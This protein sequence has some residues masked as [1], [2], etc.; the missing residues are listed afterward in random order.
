M[1]KKI[2]LPIFALIF[3]IFFSGNAFAENNGSVLS[4]VEIRFDYKKA[5]SLATNQ[6]AV[7]VE[8][9]NGKVVKTVYVSDFTAKKRGYRKRENALVHWVSAVN[10]DSLSDKEIDAVS[11]ATLNN[12]NQKFIWDLT[13]SNGSK[14]AD[15]KYF[16]KVEGTLYWQSNVLYSAQVDLSDGSLKVGEIQQNRSEQAN[17]KN[18]N[19]ILNVRIFADQ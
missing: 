16:I 6:T 4:V 14:V 18:E 10:P 5:F 19:M 9:E 1:K 15:G 7:W 17:T 2:I 11:S 12:G 13:D 8:D 3:G